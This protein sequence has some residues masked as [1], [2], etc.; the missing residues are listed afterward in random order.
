MDDD[1]IENKKKE[2]L[3]NQKILALLHKQTVPLEEDMTSFMNQMLVQSNCLLKEITH[4]CL[5]F[6]L[7]DDKL[8]LNQD[9]QISLLQD[10]SMIGLCTIVLG[11]SLSSMISHE[12]ILF[13]DDSL[14]YKMNDYHETM[15]NALS[16]S[17]CFSKIYITNSVITAHYYHHELD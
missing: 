4:G 2:C 11:Y 12:D 10:S 6:V 7:K 13:I 15:I 3:N 8:Y 16:M 5:E 17:P 9:N 14:Q 1:F